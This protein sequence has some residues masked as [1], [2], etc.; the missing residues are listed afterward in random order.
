MQNLTDRQIKILKII[1]DQYRN[2]GTPISSKLIAEVFSSKISPQTIRNELAILEKNGYLEKIH[3]SSGRIPSK[4]ALIYFNEHSNDDNISIDIEKKLESIFI[5]R[6]ND[7]DTVINDSLVILNEITSLPSIANTYFIDESLR[8]VS[9]VQLND[10][11]S[12]ML[13]VT[14]LGNI[15]KNYIEINNQNRFEDTKVCISL[16]NKFL[17]GT[18]LINLEDKIQEILPIIKNE[19]NEYEYITREVI[20]KLFDYTFKSVKKTNVVG[21]TSL[22]QYPEFSDPDILYKLIKMLE[23]GNIWKQIKHDNDQQKKKNDVKIEFRFPSNNNPK[24]TIMIASTSIK[25][26]NQ[27]REISVVGPSRVEFGQIK[28][29]LN[30]L[31]SKIEEIYNYDDIKKK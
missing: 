24:Q 21:M 17:I 2:C 22:F 4:E 7:I 15:Y 27:Q 20:K 12:L 25:I 23:T 13:I 19:V 5:K 1:A 30:Y 9:L 29:I 18:K 8:E 3:T 28:G 14:N 31:K 11:N 26:G 10:I 16:F 6:E